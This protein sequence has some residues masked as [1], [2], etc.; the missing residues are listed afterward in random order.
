M[1][2][3]KFGLSEKKNVHRVIMSIFICIYGL[4]VFRGLKSRHN[5]G[6]KMS[7]IRSAAE[8]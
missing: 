2:L 7:E 4:V 1:S 8:M 5:I 6:F 3:Y